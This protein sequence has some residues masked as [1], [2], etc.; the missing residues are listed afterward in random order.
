MSSEPDLW[1]ALGTLEP[2]QRAALVLN[3]LDGY[4]HEEISR[5]FGVRPG[6][7]SSWLSR[8]KDR[9]RV[10]LGDESK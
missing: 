3:V 6:T 7:V 4:T 10:L 1:D 2:R 8:A 9:L 5:M